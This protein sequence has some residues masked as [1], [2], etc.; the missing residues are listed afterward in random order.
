VLQEKA[1]SSNTGSDGVSEVPKQVPM[2][3]GLRA[4]ALCIAWLPSFAFFLFCVPKFHE[5]YDALRDRGE[6]PA[7]TDWLLWLAQVN[8]RFFCLP[9][10]VV[11]GLLLFADASVF[12][13][14][15]RSHSPQWF[16]WRWI[17]VIF[18]AG[19]SALFLMTTALL[20]PVVTL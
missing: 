15:A 16:Y 9:L 17:A 1:M 5:I 3:A 7:T 4:V 14:C 13:L 11:F 2:G 20:Q 6:L 12:A 8:E 18:L 10:L 19:I